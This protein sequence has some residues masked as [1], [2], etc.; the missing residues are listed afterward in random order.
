M[1]V[2]DTN[3]LN[4]PEPSIT[5]P[6]ELIEHVQWGTMDYGRLAQATGGI[7]KEKKCSVYF[8]DYKFVY[9]HAKMKSL[10]DLPPPRVYV[11]DKGCIYP[12]HIS[13]SQPYDPDAPIQTHN[14]TTALSTS[15]WLAI[16]QCMLITWSKKGWTG[17]IASAL[18]QSP[19]AMCG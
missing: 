7:L 17:L 18:N 4:W 5:D 19:E 2:D 8:V 1:Y 13:I 6:K 9:G 3:L 16:C 15:H 12:L 11:T 10:Q 14:V